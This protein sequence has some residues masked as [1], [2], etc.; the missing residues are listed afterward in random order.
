MDGS[1]IILSGSLF[2]IITNY[3][4]FILILPEKIGLKT[5]FIDN[6]FEQTQV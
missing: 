3:T 6:F 4:I 1:Q 5:I 2:K